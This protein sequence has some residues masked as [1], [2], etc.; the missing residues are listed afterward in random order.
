MNIMTVPIGRSDF[1]QS[2]SGAAR[3]AAASG[4]RGRPRTRRR[5]SEPKARANLVVR[6]RADQGRKPPEGGL[7][8][9]P[10]LGAVSRS[11]PPPDVEQGS[12]PHARTEVRPGP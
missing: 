11:Q 9:L 5:G 4:T 7:Y 3:E 12:R 1:P 10:R 8:S 2:R 6:A